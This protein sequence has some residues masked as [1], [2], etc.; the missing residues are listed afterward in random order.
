[1]LSEPLLDVNVSHQAERGM[2]GIAVA[3]KNGFEIKGLCFLYYIECLPKN[4]ENEC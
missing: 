4:G 1:M 3:A 2:L